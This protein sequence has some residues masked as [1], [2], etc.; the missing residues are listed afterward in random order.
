MRSE[1]LYCRG[2]SQSANLQIVLSQDPSSPLDF[3][4]GIEKNKGEKH[5]DSALPY[6][7]LE[8]S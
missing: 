2:N 6:I 5:I 3:S 1:K 7:D 4:F 8:K